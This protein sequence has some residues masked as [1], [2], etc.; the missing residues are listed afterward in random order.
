MRDVDELVLLDVTAT[1]RGTP[2]NLEMI[3]QAAQE[4][5]VPLSVGGGIRSTTDMR[6]VLYSGADKIVLGTASYETPDL[7]NEGATQFGAQCIVASID[8]A[9][10]DDGSYEC[11]SRCGSFRTGREPVEWAKELESRGAGEILLTSVERDGAKCGY[12]L[13]MTKRVSDS[14]GIP[15]IASGGAGNFDDLHLAIK[16]GGASAVAA[17]SIYHFTELTPRGAKDFLAQKGIPVRR[18]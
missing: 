14:V 4:C 15:V 8:F 18:Q 16:Q 2:P 17:A 6:E 5:N 9:R 10:R 11:L 3:T 1:E 12:D 7:V 13:E